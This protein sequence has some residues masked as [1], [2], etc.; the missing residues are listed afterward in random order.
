LDKNSKVSD[1]EIT[2]EYLIAN[3]DD[4]VSEIANKLQTLQE[5][6]EHGAVLISEDDEKVIGFIT[7]SEIL[8]LVS[9]GKDLSI[10]KATE[11]MRTD[12]VEVQED[13]TIGNII[14]M[15]SEKY[16]D[17]VVVVDDNGTF[18]GYFS[19]NDYKEGLA[20]LGVYDRHHRPKNEDDWQTRGIALSSLGK[21]I[22]AL[23]CFEKSIKKS[24]DQEKKWG[25]LAKRLERLN[26]LK[27]SIMCWDKVLEKNPKSDEAL[28]EKGDIYAKTQSDNQAL[29]SY[30]KAVEVN[31]SN[32]G[33]W[34]DLGL[35]Q[36]NVG[37]IEGALKSMNQAAAITG[38][39]PEF[40][41]NKGVVFDKADMLNDALK[42][43]NKATNMNNYYEEAWYNKGV[44]LNK[45]GLDKEALQCMMKI[46]MMNPNNEAVRNTINDYKEKGEFNF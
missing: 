40:W 45:L 37:D 12:H 2:D 27:E 32:S 10:K 20:V 36:A 34:L 44:A 33:A 15:I 23:K 35:E 16:P 42:C 18:V 31:P 21:K 24:N 8:D 39:S 17:A 28:K 14:P 26:K 1:M 3:A 7:F 11:I 6:T 46:L 13:D 43:Y 22:E 29:I 41:F 30:K 5:E 9:Q 4:S 19:K 25:D 38:E